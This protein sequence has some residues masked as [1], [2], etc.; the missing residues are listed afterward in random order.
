MALKENDPQRLEGADGNREELKF[1][2]PE[3]AKT[4]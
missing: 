2:V 3:T 4:K 1:R